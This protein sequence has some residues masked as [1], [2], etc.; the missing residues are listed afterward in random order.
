VDA[1]KHVMKV[2]LTSVIGGLE[3]AR[4]CGRQCP[5]GTPARRHAQPKPSQ[6][7]EPNGSAADFHGGGERIVGGNGIASTGAARRSAFGGHGMLA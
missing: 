6:A 3:K 1:R 5:E 4:A 7:T 2:F